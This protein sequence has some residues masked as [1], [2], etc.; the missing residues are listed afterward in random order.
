MRSRVEGGFKGMIYIE[1]KERKVLTREI[2]RE[3]CGISVQG[4]RRWI[5]VLFLSWVVWG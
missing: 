3:D 1:E 2:T 4:Y 5:L